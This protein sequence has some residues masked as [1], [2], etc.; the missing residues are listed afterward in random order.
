[1]RAGAARAGGGRGLGAWPR[2]RAAVALAAVR[3]SGKPLLGALACA[4]LLGA[5]VDHFAPQADTLPQAV[6]Q[7]RAG[8]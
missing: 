1:V 2:P 3:Q 8:R 6:Q 5:L 7:W 4:V